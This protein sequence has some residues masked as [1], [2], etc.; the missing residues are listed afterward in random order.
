MTEAQVITIIKD[1]KFANADG[2][3]WQFNDNNLSIDGIP[4]TTYRL[5]EEKGECILH[6]QKPLG[7]SQDY[8][9]DLIGENHSPYTILLT[10]KT[11]EEKILILKQEISI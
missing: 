10:P 7:L 11:T 9:I 5:Y 8:I 6:T 3:L 1:A 4:F 2:I